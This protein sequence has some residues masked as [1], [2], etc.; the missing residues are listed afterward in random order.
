MSAVIL[1][2]PTPDTPLCLDP[3]IGMAEYTYRSQR[4][5]LAFTWRYTRADNPETYRVWRGWV[6]RDMAKA[7]AELMADIRKHDEEKG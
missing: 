2:E 3:E 4:N 1:T 6:L 5:L 7:R